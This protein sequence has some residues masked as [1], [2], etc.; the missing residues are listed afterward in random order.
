MNLEELT[1]EQFREIFNDL[2]KEKVSLLEIADVPVDKIMIS[3]ALD[4][5]YRGQGFNVEVELPRDFETKSQ[6]LRELF[7]EEYKRMYSLTV[8]DVP[9]EVYNFKALVTGPEYEI[10]LDMMPRKGY[11]DSLKG[12]REAYFGEDS[13][14]IE[15]S[16]YDRYGLQPGMY[17][18]GPSIVEEITST[19]VVPPGARASIDR[20]LN[21]IIDLGGI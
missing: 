1:P 9:I 6:S 10:K 8:E 12:K 19:C 20:Y 18:D 7:E 13:G 2:I 16:V 17:I 5:R 11:Q 4:M 14:F 15:C 3:K 21:I